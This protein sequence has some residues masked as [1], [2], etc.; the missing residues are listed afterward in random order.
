[1][2]QFGPD[3]SYTCKNSTIICILLALLVP[4]WP[5]S[6]PLFLLIAYKTY[7]DPL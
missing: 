7:R 1:M 5:V 6:L 4:F 2:C 3:G